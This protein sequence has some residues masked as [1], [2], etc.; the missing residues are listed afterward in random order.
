MTRRHSPSASSSAAPQ[1]EGSVLAAHQTSHRKVRRRPRGAPA[2]ASRPRTRT[3]RSEFAG[4][5][6]RRKSGNLHMQD[7][8]LHIGRG[9]Q[10]TDPCERSRRVSRACRS[11]RRRCTAQ[12]PGAK[13]LR[14]EWPYKIKLAKPPAPPR[15]E[16]DAIATGSTQYARKSRPYRTERRRS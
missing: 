5:Q 8:R 3:R 15:G 10:E 1:E 9:Q 6:N 4:A 13:T 14:P 11:S 16:P 12:R 7:A 2:P